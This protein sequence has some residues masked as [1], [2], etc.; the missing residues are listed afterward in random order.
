MEYAL[1][2]E[3]KVSISGVDIETEVVDM[4]ANAWIT[5]EVANHTKEEQPVMASVVVAQG[6]AREQVEIAE[7][8][9]PFGGVIEAVIRITDHTM[10][11]PDDSGERPQFDCLVGL[12]IADE[13]Q[14]V[15]AIKFDVE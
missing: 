5:I 7:Q 6:E 1:P 4:I 3:K 9:T 13:V 10:W 2:E 12:E 11:Q 15:K 14:D 8:I